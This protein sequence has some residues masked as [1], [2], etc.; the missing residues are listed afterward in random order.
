MEYNSE[1]SHARNFEFAALNVNKP[2]TALLCVKAIIKDV[3]SRSYCC[4][5][6]NLLSHKN[7]SM[8]SP[9]IGR[10]FNTM[11]AYSTDIKEWL[12]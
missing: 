8:C 10:F 2:H 5:N 9:M 12:E 4:Y 3:F 7:Y 11:I 6:G 1:C